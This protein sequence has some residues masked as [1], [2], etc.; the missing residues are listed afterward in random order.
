VERES[1]GDDLGP[2][3]MPLKLGPRF[4]AFLGSPALNLAVFTV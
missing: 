4:S 3:A 1:E 2:A